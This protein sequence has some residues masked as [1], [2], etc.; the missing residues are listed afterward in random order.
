M[1]NDAASEA[2]TLGAVAK[3]DDDGAQRARS[4]GQDT[5]AS[6]ARS[7]EQDNRVPKEGLEPSHPKAQEPKSCVSANSTT[8]AVKSGQSYDSAAGGE[9]RRTP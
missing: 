3:S 9:R 1:S 5:P 7:R 6:V 8:P 2:S 4:R